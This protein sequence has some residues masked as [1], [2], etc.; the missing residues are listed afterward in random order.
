MKKKIFTFLLFLFLSSCGYE[1]IYSLKNR[2][3]YAFSINTLVF[4]GDR[5]V[6]LK[7]KQI[8]NN[9]R[10]PSI[11][12]KKSFGLKISS[13]SEKIITA[14]DA[15]GDAIRFKNEITVN[16][17]VST[18]GAIKTSFS[19]AENFNY[20]NNSNTPE[21]RAYEKQIKNNLTEAA[22]DKIIFKLAHI[23]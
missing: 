14:K 21:L 8:L 9:Y 20:N 2:V 10:N 19:V 4:S 12:E 15:S 16:V 3:N 1:A 6:N 22:V 18:G 5:E 13:S 11:E 7:I 17:Q 23:K